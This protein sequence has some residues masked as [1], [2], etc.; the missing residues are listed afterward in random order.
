MV[1][2]SR[3]SYR[4]LNCCLVFLLVLA[5]VAAFYA[6]FLFHAPAQAARDIELTVRYSDVGIV[7]ARAGLT[8]EETLLFLKERGASVGIPEYS[9]WG[10]G[11]TRLLCLKQPELVGEMSLNPELFPRVFLEEKAKEAGLS[12][13]DYIVFMPAGPGLNRSRTPPGAFHCGADG[14]VQ[15]SALLP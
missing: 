10:C 14:A 13:G 1:F 8:V 3:F 7:A 4:A 5:V 9:L 2:A 11:V 12:F 6:S 15:D